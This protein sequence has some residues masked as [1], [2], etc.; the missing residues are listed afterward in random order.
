MSRAVGLL[1]MLRGVGTG[2]LLNRCDGRLLLYC[3]CMGRFAFTLPVEEA[4]PI[5][6]GCRHVPNRTSRRCSQFALPTKAAVTDGGNSVERGALTVQT[7]WFL[8]AR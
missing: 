1:K 4:I 3:A 7:E 5:G 6:R 8:K 2:I